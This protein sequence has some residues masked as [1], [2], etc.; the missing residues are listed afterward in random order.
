VEGGVTQLSQGFE[1]LSGEAKAN[2]EAATEKAKKDVLQGLD[3]YNSKA[4]NYADKLPGGF[5]EK[6]A[7]YPWVVISVTLVIGLL[8]GTLLKPARKTLW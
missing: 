1:K 3:K 8:L 6:A 4:Q 7:K 2:V 5:A